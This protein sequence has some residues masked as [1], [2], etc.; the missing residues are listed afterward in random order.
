M[1]EH[2]ILPFHFGLHPFT[3]TK[4]GNVSTSVINLYFEGLNM[5]EKG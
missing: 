1:P 2:G 3:G 5:Q 4:Y